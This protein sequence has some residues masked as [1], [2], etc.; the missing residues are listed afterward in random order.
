MKRTCLAGAVVAAFAVGIV[1]TSATQP[2]NDRR[3]LT[4]EQLIDIRHPSSPMWSPD[5]HHVASVWDR[6]GVSKVYVSDLS[7]SPRELTDAGSQL[8]AAF[9]SA[10]GTALFVP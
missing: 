3:P 1:Q 8:T 4:V 7:G 10:D 9:W 5:G 2:S 6:A